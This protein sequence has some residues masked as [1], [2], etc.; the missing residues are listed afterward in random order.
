[1]R[2][3]FQ[4]VRARLALAIGCAAA[5]I[6]LPAAAQQTSGGAVAPAASSPQ[7][8][9]PL[10]IEPTRRQDRIEYTMP[11]RGAQEPSA[12]SSTPPPEA[13]PPLLLPPA[14]PRPTFINSP[15]W[16]RL[17]QVEFPERAMSRGI[18]E[19]RV[20]LR[21][22][23]QPSGAVSDCA[24]T[25]ETPAGAGFG[26]AALSGARRARL[27]PRTVEGAAVGAQ[28]SFTV[29]FLAP[30]EPPLLDTIEEPLWARAPRASLP[31]RARRAGIEAAQ[32]TLDCE[33]DHG[34]NG[35][36]RACVVKQEDPAGYGLGTAALQS[37]RNATIAPL[38][39]ERTAPNARAVFTVHFGER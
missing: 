18:A 13:A 2:S 7:T 36:L 1:M 19:G 17:P 5:A 20:V 6:G 9:A 31:R 16:A 38:D 10:L 21:C 33:I 27:S 14:P 25:E 8:P 28:V 15:G 39:L 22:A 12:A 24:V 30:E 4:S 3:G 37:V 11:P 26:Q 34:R 29:R 32:V 23:V 35:R